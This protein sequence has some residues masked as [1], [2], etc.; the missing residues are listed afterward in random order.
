M[1]GLLLPAAPLLEVWTFWLSIMLVW[2]H[3]RV[4]PVNV[5]VDILKMEDFTGKEEV[6]SK[7]RGGKS[8]P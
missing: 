1:I 7:R 5:F 4:I 6:S 8:D 3:L 2:G